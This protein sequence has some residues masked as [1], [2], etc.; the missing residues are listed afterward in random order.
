MARLSNKIAR[1]VAFRVKYFFLYRL[2]VELKLCVLK[3]L[4]EHAAGI[5]IGAKKIFVA[6]E[7]QQVVSFETFTEDFRHAVDYLRHHQVK[8]VAMEATG[9]Y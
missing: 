6:V 3:K 2:F 5:D 1:S 7:R 9:V 8:T 4:R